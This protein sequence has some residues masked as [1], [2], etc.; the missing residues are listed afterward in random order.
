LDISDFKHFVTIVPDLN[1]KFE[2]IIKN[3]TAEHFKKFKVPFFKFIPVERYRQLADLCEMIKYEPQATIYKEGEI[4]NAFYLIVH[5]RIES[6]KNKNNI[7]NIQ[8]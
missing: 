5:G 8:N 4:G 6:V 2:M 3:R 1:S 7:F